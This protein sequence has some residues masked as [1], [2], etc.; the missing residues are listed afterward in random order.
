MRTTRT[1]LGVLGALCLTMVV[2]FADMQVMSRCGGSAIN[3]WSEEHRPCLYQ[4]GQCSLVTRE[5]WT[6]ALVAELTFIGCMLV[7]LLLMLTMNRAAEVDQREKRMWQMV[8]GVLCLGMA[9]LFLRD[10]WGK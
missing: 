2:M 1:K 8:M 9:S 7:L 3:R 10:Y 6:L 4:R 5:V